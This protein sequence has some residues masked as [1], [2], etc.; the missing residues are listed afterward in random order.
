MQV[1]KS[2]LGFSR[3]PLPFIVKA[4]YIYIGN[5]YPSMD[6]V[7]VIAILSSSQLDFW[8]SI[9]SPKALACEEHSKNN[10]NT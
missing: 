2:A 10:G 4:I 3:G 1:L 6:V 8:K 5:M 7:N 9:P